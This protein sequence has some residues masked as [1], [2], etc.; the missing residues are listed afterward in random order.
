MENAIRITRFNDNILASEPWPVYFLIKQKY[1]EFNKNLGTI[2]L[3][4]RQGI[5]RPVREQEYSWTDIADVRLGEKF[6]SDQ[7]TPMWVY[8]VQVVLTSGKRIVL[9]DSYN[10]AEVLELATKVR[11][12]LLN[13]QGV[14]NSELQALDCY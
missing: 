12:F 10:R 11:Q 3:I 1:V 13:D 14:I 2:L 4:E 8:A 5:G 6:H 7:E 9:S